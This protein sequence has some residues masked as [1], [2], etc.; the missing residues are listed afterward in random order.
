MFDKRFAVGEKRVTNSFYIWKL[1]ST[2]LQKVHQD[3]REPPREKIRSKVFITAN[4]P[5]S[6]KKNYSQNLRLCSSLSGYEFE[7]QASFDQHGCIANSHSRPELLWYCFRFR[8]QRAVNNFFTTPIWNARLILHTASQVSKDL[9]LSPRFS[10]WKLEARFI[11]FL[12]PKIRGCNPFAR[13]KPNE[14]WK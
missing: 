12:H 10:G 7:W 9:R 8:Y 2:D 6:G 3:G 5:S 4:A 14:V 11:F 13:K 1:F